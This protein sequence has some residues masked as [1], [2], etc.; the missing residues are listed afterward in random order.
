MCYSAQIDSHIRRLMREEGV[1][2]EYEEAERIF[3]RRLAD[4]RI[5][6]PRAFEQQFLEPQNDAEA[7]IKG[8]I[9]QYRAETENK[10]TQE[11]FKQRKRLSDAERAL[12]TKETKKAR[13]DVRIASTK[14]EANRQRLSRL[15]AADIDVE[16]ERIFPF[17]YAPIMVQQD[18]RKVLKLARYH[19]RQKNAPEFID[20]KYPGLYNARRDNLEKFW[21]N[22]FGHSHALMVVTSFFENVERDGKNVVL[23]FNPQPR[24]RMLV[25]C[26]Y[27]EWTSP[28]EGEMV[29]FAAVTDDPPPEVAAAGHDRCIVNLQPQNVE[30]WLTPEGRTSAELQAILDEKQR[31]Y[32]EHAIAA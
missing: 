4:S 7:R 9:E 15:R 16:D 29:S 27:S 23:H 2:I 18:G 25:A 31:P 11:L 17:W 12:Q 1:T 10:L 5:R 32:Y 28:S 24:D 13:E 30:R 6:I 26:L 20:R 21:R 14:I 3:L 19:L 22:E 8:W